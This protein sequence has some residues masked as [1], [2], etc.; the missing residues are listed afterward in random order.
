MKKFKNYIR[1]TLSDTL[2]IC[3]EELKHIFKD[4]GVLVIFFAAGL[5]YPILYG[6][7]YQNELLRDIP[8]AVVDMSGSNLS[9]EFKRK[10]DATPELKM[11]FVCNSLEEAK[12]LYE[13]DLVHAIVFI[14]NTFSSDIYSGKQAHIIAYSNMSSMM[15][16]KGLYAAVNYVSLDMGKEI[17]LNRLKKSGLTDYQAIVRANPILY[18]SKSLFNPKGG[19]ASFLMPAVLILVIQQTLVLG[20]GM[21]AGTAREENTFHNLI[22][23]QQKYH[24]SMRIVIGKAAAYFLIYSFITV[25]NLMAIPYLFNLPH[26]ENPLV[27]VPFILPFLLSG[28]FLGMSVSVFFWNRENSLLLYLFTS[29]P[30]LFL[31]GFSWPATHIHIFWKMISYFFPST[32]GIQAFLKINS[33]GASFRQ[34]GFEL[35]GLWML[36]AV[37]FLFS[38]LA[39]RWQILRSE[40]IRAMQ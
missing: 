40:R 15:Y 4:S 17:Q 13:K 33:M 26:L 11:S 1:H 8:T 3:C 32:F 37:Y 35:T 29:L 30:L 20:I 39:Y 6:F 31:S 27:L 19:F 16:Y 10:L 38:I 12:E 14:P 36:T 22:P 23:F 2:Q 5:I 18:E 28:I 21:L 9:R 7:T 25:Y 24:G 34:V